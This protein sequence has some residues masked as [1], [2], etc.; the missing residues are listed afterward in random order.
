MIKIYFSLLFIAFSVISFSNP[1]INVPYI[2]PP[3]IDGYVTEWEG[4]TK[5]TTFLDLNSPSMSKHK[6][7]VWLG[8]DRDNIYLAYR[9]YKPT[10]PKALA[11]DRNAGSF[12]EDDDFEF[13]FTPKKDSG[14]YQLLVNATG[15]YR[16][17]CDS[18]MPK[19]PIN[20]ET[21]AHISDKYN[22]SADLEELYWEGEMKVPFSELGIR[23]S[24]EIRFLILGS[25]QLLGLT[26]YFVYSDSS[27]KV[28]ANITDTSKW[29][30]LSFGGNKG[31]D[32]KNDYANEFSA[33]NDIKAVFFSDGEVFFEQTVKENYEPLPKGFYVLKT[34]YYDGD[35]LVY[36]NSVNC[37]NMKVLETSFEYNVLKCKFD[38]TVF[39]EPK[40]FLITLSQG[41]KVFAGGS[42]HNNNR[43]ERIWDMSS[44]PK[45]E[46]EL[47]VNIPGV[48]NETRM[49]INE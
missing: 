45:G 39:K 4:A 31:I 21:K 44:L 22:I 14:F 5:L 3:N 49:I 34:D 47:S 46:Y 41:E 11:T 42:F 36:S 2:D 43:F 25:Y 27:N 7:Y 8:C 9:F 16:D 1:Y 29:A 30:T 20:C 24:D 26:D 40:V 32:F 38:F 17:I 6:A 28:D 33:T 37:S 48:Y 15:Y 18:G 10:V 12:W 35:T 19:K 23:S 13:F